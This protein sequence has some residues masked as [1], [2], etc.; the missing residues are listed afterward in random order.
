M[1][2]CRRNSDSDWNTI[3]AHSRASKKNL[4]YVWRETKRNESK[5]VKLGSFEKIYASM[6]KRWEEGNSGIRGVGPLTCYD[7]CIYIC[8][9]HSIS[10][11]GRV[12]LMGPGPQRAADKLKIWK[13]SAECKKCNITGES[14]VM[15]KD[16][17]AAFQKSTFE[18]DKE[19]VANGNEDYMESYLCCWE[20]E[21][22]KKD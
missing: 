12:W 3:R 9:N 8:K 7:L 10:L 11:N 4:K 20:S 15:I 2:H 21:M 18:Y 1:S 5:Y 17:R 6:R 19:K 13:R 14:Y 16:V 22:R